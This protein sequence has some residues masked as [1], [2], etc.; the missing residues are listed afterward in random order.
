MIERS[1]PYDLGGHAEIHYRLAG[2][3][4][5]F[6][7]P[8]THVVAVLPDSVAAERSR[9]H[10]PLVAGLLKGRTVLLVEDNMIIAMD[11]EDA[12]RDLG[13]EVLTAASA[14]RAREALALM[15]VDLAVLDFNLGA[16]TSLPIADVLAE[17]GIPFIF[18]TGYG[19]GL[20]LP[21][22]FAH[23][24]LVKKP[25]SGATLA[26]ALAPAMDAA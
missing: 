4:A 23:V 19:D 10:A 26:Q 6:C 7:I 22:R 16:E 18:A 13:A 25:Y 15:P 8:S 21:S 11:G 14:G 3:E 2:I 24:T 1:I 5:H 9:T 17:R 20:D 12:L